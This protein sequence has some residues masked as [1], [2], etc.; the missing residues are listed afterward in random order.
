MSA[1]LLM[2]IEM[3]GQPDQVIAPPGPAAMIDATPERVPEVE[4]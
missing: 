4:R 2:V 1:G 3:Q